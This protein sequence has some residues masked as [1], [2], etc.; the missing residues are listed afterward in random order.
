MGYQNL[1]RI[2]L[3]IGAVP[4]G[5][6]R[7]WTGVANHFTPTSLHL[8]DRTAVIKRILISS[9]ANTT[10]NVH[11]YDHTNDVFAYTETSYRDEK[12]SYFGFIPLNTSTVSAEGAGGFFWY[13]SD[14]DIDGLFVSSPYNDDE[15]KIAMLVENTGANP[16]TECLVTIEY[17]ILAP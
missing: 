13:Q 7:P 17:L 4:A 2:T 9:D 8:R 5:Q 11:F 12:I 15:H 14:L 10:W 16:S 3:N 1:G 6:Y